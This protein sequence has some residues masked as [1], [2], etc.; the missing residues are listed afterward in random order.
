MAVRWPA[1]RA[2]LHPG[3]LSSEGPALLDLKSLVCLERGLGRAVPRVWERGV[4]K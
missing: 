1:S 4:R 3:T 2:T